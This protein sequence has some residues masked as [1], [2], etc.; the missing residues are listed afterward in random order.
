L[1]EDHVRNKIV[2]L[3][4][5]QMRKNPANFIL[6]QAIV[7]KEQIV[8]IITLQK[9]KRKSKNISNNIKRSSKLSLNKNR[10]VNR[11]DKDNIKKS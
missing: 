5:Y 6:K 10:V 9:S 11:K 4:I 1:K 2:L 8:I 3:F 7:E